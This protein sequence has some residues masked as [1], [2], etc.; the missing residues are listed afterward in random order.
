MRWRHIMTL[1]LALIVSTVSRG[2]AQELGEQRVATLTI[3]E[4][5]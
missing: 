2:W 4:E 5:V 1:W 3:R